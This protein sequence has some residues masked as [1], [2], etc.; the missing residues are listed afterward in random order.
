MRE[1]CRDSEIK[2]KTKILISNMNQKC[3]S[4]KKSLFLTLSAWGLIIIYSTKAVFNIG[5]VLH[6]I[7][8]L[9]DNEPYSFVIFIVAPFIITLFLIPTICSIGLLL[10]RNWGRLGIMIICVLSVV[11]A[12][13]SIVI[14]RAFY[15]RQ[16]LWI[17]FSLSVFMMLNS[18][19]TKRELQ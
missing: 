7:A 13:S 16:I 6:D 15:P 12:S 14:F 19:R 10:R 11:T 4:S 18:E 1:V 5:Y 9:Y 2:K 17:V 8:R 3:D